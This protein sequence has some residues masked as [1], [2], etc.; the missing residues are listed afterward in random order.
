VARI[1]PGID[2]DLCK[3]VGREKGKSRQHQVFFFSRVCGILH[4]LVN[5]HDETFP[6]EAVKFSLLI[7]PAE[8][9]RHLA[10]HNF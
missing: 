1:V 3:G 10:V 8:V 7:F 5:G 6:N 4:L 2:D 9:I